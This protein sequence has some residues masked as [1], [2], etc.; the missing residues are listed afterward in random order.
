MIEGIS[1]LRGSPIQAESQIYTQVKTV[2]QQP[3]VPPDA[4]EI[5]QKIF[6]DYG[7]RVIDSDVKFN[8]G[9]VQ[10]INETLD[11]I[12]QKY[13]QHLRGVKEI[14]KN[15]KQ[16]VKLKKKFIHAGG[17]YD[18][19]N[20]R[21]YLFDNLEDADELEKVLIHEIGH[22]VNYYNLLFAKF[23]EFVKINDWQAVEFRPVFNPDNEYYSFSLKKIMVPPEELGKVW[24]VFSLNSLAENRDTSGSIVLEARPSSTWMPGPWSKNPLEQFATLYELFMNERKTFKEFARK[25][26]IIAKDWN[27]FRK[28]VFAKEV[29]SG[30]AFSGDPF[31]GQVIGSKIKPGRAKEPNEPLP[32][33]LGQFFGKSNQSE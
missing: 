28:E 5:R 13:R 25:D 19:A 23:M 16:R 6:K 18:E 31:S 7:I 33:D 3:F 22:A 21:V 17:A 11:K 29:F 15:K 2:Q 27:F 26:P 20:R 14:V 12:A 4:L 9:E 24:P 30:E 8:R 32:V 10:V 1:P